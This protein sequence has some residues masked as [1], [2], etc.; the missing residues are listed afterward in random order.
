MRTKTVA[1]RTFSP[2]NSSFNISERWSIALIL[3][4]TAVIWSSALRIGFSTDDYIFIQHLAPVKS[5]IDVFRP[6]WS[7][8]PN[9]PYWRPVANASAALDFLLWGWNGQGFHA[10]N[11]ILH[12]IATFL[13]FF[14]ARRVLL[15]PQVVSAL[16][17]LFFGI[18]ASHESNI[19]W[20]AARAD[21]LATIFTM[22]AMLAYRRSMDNNVF[23]NGKDRIGLL[24]SYAAFLLALLSKENAVLALPLILLV[25]ELPYIL[26]K[27]TN[28][29]SGLGRVIP[30]IVILSLVFIVRSHF[31]T[32]LENIEPLLSEGSQA[33]IAFLRNGV[34]G[35]GYALIPLDLEQATSLLAQPKLLLWAIGA[36][37]FITIAVFCIRMPQKTWKTYYRP[38]AFFVIAS[39]ITM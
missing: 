22:I 8:D 23:G 17:A 33:F 14:F 24:V 19:L 16:T 28:W 11:F 35:I 32:P 39:F 31:T 21:V 37:I 26:N 38:A 25:I 20:P 6:F 3:A 18:A 9:P 4:V 2:P 29:Q 7:V 30:M 34:Y 1:K 27:R 12:L 13:V 36:I 5:I 10:T 15:I